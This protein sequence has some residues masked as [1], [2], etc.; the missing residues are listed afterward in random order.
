MNVE[1]GS[2]LR[3]TIGAFERAALGIP[4]SAPDAICAKHIKRIYE[5]RRHS[6]NGNR[7]LLPGSVAVYRDF[8]ILVRAKQQTR[9]LL[10]NLPQKVAVFEKDRD[11]TYGLFPGSRLIFDREIIRVVDTNEAEA[12]HKQATLWNEL[13]QCPNSHLVRRI[14]SPEE[15][16][17]LC[18]IDEFYSD[19][20]SVQ[21]KFNA[22]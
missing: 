2:L 7:R 16:A 11:D 8:I 15:L 10:P 20:Q 12:A 9:I 14:S 13:L 5:A 4:L 17:I 18:D 22:P 3:H 21:Q 1:L 19:P 6:L